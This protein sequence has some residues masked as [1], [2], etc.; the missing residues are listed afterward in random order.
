MKKLVVLL[1]IAVIAVSCVTNSTKQI[2]IACERIERYR[3]LDAD[4]LYCWECV[5]NWEEEENGVKVEISLTSFDTRHKSTKDTLVNL[6][7]EHKTMVDSLNLRC[8]AVSEN[9]SIER[10]KESS[11]DIKTNG[12]QILDNALYCYKV[13]KVYY[14]ERAAK[15]DG[16]VI[17]RSISK[18][19]RAER[20]EYYPFNKLKSELENTKKFIEMGG[21]QINIE[22]EIIPCP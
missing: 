16:Q 17:N 1:F 15:V 10:D 7:R 6:M 12:I 19:E 3:S 14:T 22:V 18:L 4:S 11:V 9:H 2:D 8:R 13:K 5:Q 21:D 20:L